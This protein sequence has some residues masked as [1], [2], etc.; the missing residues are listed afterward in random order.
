MEKLIQ[1]AQIV[2]ECTSGDIILTAN[3]DK[4]TKISL[5]YDLIINGKIVNDDDVFVYLYEGQKKVESLKKLK[6]RLKR[7]LYNLLLLLDSE[8]ARFTERMKAIHEINRRWTLFSMVFYRTNTI[9]SLDIAESTINK[10]IK[11]EATEHTVFF[12]KHLA[13]QYGYVVPNK[14]KYKKYLAIYEKYTTLLQKELIVEGYYIKISTRHVA[15]KEEITEVFKNDVKVC[16]D[17]YLE[18]SKSFESF[19]LDWH[20]RQ[21]VSFYYTIMDDNDRL[22]ETCENALKVFANKAYYSL[23]AK[24]TF[25]KD[26]IKAYFNQKRFSD[27]RKIVNENISI[28]TPFNNIWL[29][30]KNLLFFSY[31]FEKNF[32]D[33]H[34]TL[35]PV[36]STKVQV[37]YPEKYQSWL[38]K[39]AYV[40]ILIAFGK[41]DKEV[42]KAYPPRNFKLSKFLNEVPKYSSDKKGQNTSILIAQMLLLLID[43]KYDK[44][45]DRL[46][47]L[48][49]YC[50][51]Y[52]KNDDTLR[53][54]CFIKMLLKLPDADYHPLRVARYVTKFQKKLKNKPRTFSNQF[55]Q[56]EIID[57]EILWEFVIEFLEKQR[58]R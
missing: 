48:N 24:Q 17:H 57:Y 13:K 10:S 18:I 40:N 27:V 55:F 29:M 52:L 49:Q 45:L 14:V 35:H 33:L 42:L 54:N 15:N 28:S 37:K 53:A 1:L 50:H 44:I 26:L 30:N 36:L 19:S 7:R 20:G 43:K 32:N 11:F 12:S 16:C 4:D 51:R 3:D 25:S 39:E 31:S 8:S 47:A 58:R 9:L 6:L 46:D 34:K 41:V 38:I 23:L 56:S 22:I 5:L 2:E 21:L